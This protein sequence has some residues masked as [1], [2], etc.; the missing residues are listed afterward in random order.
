VD[1]YTCRAF[2]PQTPINYTKE[3]FGDNLI[4]IA[5]RE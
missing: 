1:I 5:W 2:N 3:F 4:D